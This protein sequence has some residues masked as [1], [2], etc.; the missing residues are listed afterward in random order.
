MLPVIDQLQHRYFMIPSSHNGVCENDNY[1]ALIYP[2]EV[3]L[4]RE[5]GQQDC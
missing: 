4:R 1:D 2:I 3:T 5:I